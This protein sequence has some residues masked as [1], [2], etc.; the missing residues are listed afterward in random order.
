MYIIYLYIYNIYII[1]IYVYDYYCLIARDNDPNEP[2]TV[3]IWA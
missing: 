1:Y 2:I 3:R